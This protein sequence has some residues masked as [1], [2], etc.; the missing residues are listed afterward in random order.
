MELEGGTRTQLP[1]SEGHEGREE[2][3]EAS[4]I[5][6]DVWKTCMAD[7]Q[8]VLLREAFTEEQQ[9]WEAHS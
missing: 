1:K 6:R 2:K 8:Y 5:F 3:L 9:E 7:K 4:N